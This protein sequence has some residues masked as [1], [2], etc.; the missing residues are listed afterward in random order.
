MAADAAAPL[1][2]PP[3]RK[4][5][6]KTPQPLPSRVAS[7]SREARHRLRFPLAACFGI[8]GTGF[9]I[10]F[11]GMNLLVDFLTTRR[12]RDEER[13]RERLERSAQRWNREH[14][15][16]MAAAAAARAPQQHA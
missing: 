1:D 7:F 4:A 14:A 6:T 10:K 3:G 9:A 11:F 16:A 2:C 12:L 15:E 5:S 13:T 8:I